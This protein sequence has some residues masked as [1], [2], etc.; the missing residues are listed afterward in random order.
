MEEIS[1]VETKNGKWKW[2]KQK[3][4]LYL[5][6]FFFITYIECFQFFLSPLYSSKFFFKIKCFSRENGKIL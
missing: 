2:K 3:T 4:L 6:K 1:S 5:V